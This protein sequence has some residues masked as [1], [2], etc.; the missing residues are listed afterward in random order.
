M[1]DRI[2]RIKILLD[3]TT[4]RYDEV[5]N[6]VKSVNGLWLLGY[7]SGKKSAF[8]QVLQILKEG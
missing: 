6:E 2:E 8:E 4:A 7:T 5:R 1:D 3:H